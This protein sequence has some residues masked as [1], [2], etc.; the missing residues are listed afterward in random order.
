MKIKT[1]SIVTSLGICLSAGAYSRTAITNSANYAYVFTNAH[2]HVNGGTTK[3]WLKSDAFLQTGGTLTL[4]FADPETAPAGLNEFIFNIANF[5]DS[6]PM[7]ARDME[8]NG[9]QGVQASPRYLAQR[10]TK[11]EY[12]S[13]ADG[14]TCVAYSG[15]WYVP[16]DATYSFYSYGRRLLHL[17]ID[18][19][20]I[21]CGTSNY[22]VSYKAGVAL[23]QGWHSVDMIAGPASSD[24]GVVT[25]GPQFGKGLLYSPVNAVRDSFPAGG[26][27][28]TAQTDGHRVSTASA[29][30]I[31]SIASAGGNVVIDCA[32]FPH[33]FRIAGNV[34]RK[35]GSGTITFANLADDAKLYVG[36]DYRKTYTEGYQCNY[37]DWAN[38]SIPE[39]VE[40]VFLGFSMVDSYFPS[41]RAHSVASCATTLNCFKNDFFGT[42]EQIGDEFVYPNGLMSLCLMTN[43]VIDSRCRIKVKSDQVLRAFAGVV[44]KNTA[45]AAKVEEGRVTWTRKDLIMKVDNEIALD[46][47]IYMQEPFGRFPDFT[48]VVTGKTGY[49]YL[50]GWSGQA[51]FSGREINLGGTSSCQSRNNTFHVTGKKAYLGKMSIGGD[52]GSGY[53]APIFHY[54]ADPRDPET[55][56][57]GIGELAFWGTK[58]YYDDAVGYKRHGSVFLVYSNNTVNVGKMTGGGG[59]IWGDAPKLSGNLDWSLRQNNYGPASF[60]VGSISS[61][62]RLWVATN[63]SFTVSNLAQKA[64]FRYDFVSNSVNHAKLDIVNAGGNNAASGVYA[65][66]LYMLPSRV[67]GFEGTINLTGGA[68]CN[69]RTYNLP[70]DFDQGP[71]GLYNLNGCDGSGTL[72]SAPATGTINVTFNGE[73]TPERGRYALFGCTTGGGLLDGWTVNLPKSFHKGRTVELMRD[74]TG[75]WLKVSGAGVHIIV[76]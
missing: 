35:S 41:S 24:D 3:I 73:N 30:I 61:D 6:E 7:F 14:V 62:M 56:P 49:A 28:F 50:A 39:G 63:I 17:S 40:I 76:K 46:G 22:S 36:N 57:L 16:A 74:A 23:K 44:N 12:A 66:D 21:L 31:P 60:V 29:A 71:D 15:S 52:C 65:T 59:F 53:Q 25:V 75:L 67:K 45:A 64:E 2:L 26:Y 55:E 47:Q 48:G 34:F 54:G 4:S 32:N 1:L 58:P 43:N 10:L 42:Y 33:G 5:C 38:V 70:I 37:I 9:Y 19:A 69:G 72:A 51:R 68:N 27:E 20:P 18:G 13:I 8:W 11:S